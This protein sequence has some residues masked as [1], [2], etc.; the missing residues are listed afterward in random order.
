MGSYHLLKHNLPEPLRSGRCFICNQEINSV[1]G[2]LQADLFEY[3]CNNCN[4]EV[5]IT[6]TGSYLSSEKFSELKSNPLRLKHEQEEIRKLK[7]GRVIYSEEG[8]FIK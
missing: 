8:I 6:L 7:S 5:I 1:P 2:D 3:T 4:H